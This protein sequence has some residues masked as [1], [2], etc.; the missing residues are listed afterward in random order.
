MIYV[1]AGPN[2]NDRLAGAYN[3]EWSGGGGPK[4]AHVSVA[5]RVYRLNFHV[6]MCY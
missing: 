4:V 1:G 3:K 5:G 2:E 6:I